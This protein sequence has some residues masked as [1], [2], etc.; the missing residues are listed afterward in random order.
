MPVQKLTCLFQQARAPDSPVII[1]G[2]HYDM[3][4]ADKRTD[5][6]TNLRTMISD[7]Y[8][9]T[10]FGGRVQNTRERGLPKVMAMIEVSCKTGYHIRELRQL[11]YNTSFE[12]K[13]KGIRG[14]CV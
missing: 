8:I 4:E 5:Y 10:E 1:V 12:I 7:N 3:L 11:I 13:E 9:A 14:P 6:L 2:T